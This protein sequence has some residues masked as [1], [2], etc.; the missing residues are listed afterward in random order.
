MRYYLETCD[1]VLSIH[2]TF[3]GA[4]EA[5]KEYY[6]NDTTGFVASIKPTP[7]LDL[8]YTVGAVVCAAAAGVML[9]WR[10]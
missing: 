8:G 5:L 4:S 10:G 1:K 9:A 6:H 7:W 3:K 2:L